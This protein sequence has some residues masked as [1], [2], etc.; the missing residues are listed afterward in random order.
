MAVNFIAVNQLL[1]K[2]SLASMHNQLTFLKTVDR[3]LD[4]AWGDQVNGFK[5]GDTYKIN[6]PAQFSA[7]VGNS[8]AFNS[9]TGEFTSQSFTEDPIFVTLSTND[10]RFIPVSFNSKELTLAIDMKDSRIGDPAGLKLASVL[11]QKCINETVTRGGTAFITA[12]PAVVGLADMLKAQSYLDSLTAPDGDRSCLIPPT[13]NAS[14]ANANLSIFTPVQNADV[15]AKGYI[16]K[17]AG[18]DFYRSNLLP[19]YAP[20][21]GLAGTVASTVLEGANTVALTGMTNGTYKAGTIITFVGNKRV[22]PETK[23]LTSIDYQ[24]SLSI[25]MV[26]AGG[27]GTATFDDSAKI[28]SSADAGNR[29]NISSLPVATEVI[30]VLGSTTK[31]YYQTVMYHRD[32]FTATV[33]PLVTDLPGAFASR[34]DYEGT[35]VRVMFQTQAG[36]DTVVNRFDVMSVGK[37]LRDQ[38][39]VR[40]LSEV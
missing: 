25:D 17:F 20:V 7:V 39:T 13:A 34:S 30:A 31:S 15:Y 33:V 26:V 36:T 32:A 5:A 8:M 37:L 19:I 2:N 3:Q 11:E 14:L 23:A 1:A 4:S 18:A 29:Q 28:Y 16:N 24:I 10:Q 27:N 9:G 40:V 22:N 12:S 21:P 6:R 38:Y 35:S